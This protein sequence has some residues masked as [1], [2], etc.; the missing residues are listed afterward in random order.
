V[1]FANVTWS[2]RRG[3]TDVDRDNDDRSLPGL[4]VID[5]LA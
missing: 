2:M 3:S 1:G 4:A 5:V